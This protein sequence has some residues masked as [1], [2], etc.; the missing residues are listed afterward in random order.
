MCINFKQLCQLLQRCSL[1]Y[2][3]TGISRVGGSFFVNNLKNPL[4]S[5]F[6]RADPLSEEAFHRLAIFD[7]AD[8]DRRDD[9]VGGRQLQKLNEPLQLGKA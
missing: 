4:S 1:K 3:V 5:S 6:G 8:V 2:T 7:V 9:V